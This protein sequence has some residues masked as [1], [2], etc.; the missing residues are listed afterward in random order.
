MVLASKPSELSVF[1][2][3]KKYRE[4]NLCLAKLERITSETNAIKFKILISGLKTVFPTTENIRSNDNSNERSEVHS[5]RLGIFW[6]FSIAKEKIV[7]KE[8]V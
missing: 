6:A 3:A 4:K 7:K 5:E 8:T 1:K 2:M